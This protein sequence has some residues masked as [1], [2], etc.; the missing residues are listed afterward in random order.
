MTPAENLEHELF[1]LLA[2]ARVTN[3]LAV[4]GL[5]FVVIEHI[6]NFKEEIDLSFNQPP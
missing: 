6:A 2:D 1:G 5:A 3:S 4:A